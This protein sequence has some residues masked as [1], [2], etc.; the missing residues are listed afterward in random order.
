LAN[1]VEHYLRIAT[2]SIGYLMKVSFHIELMEA[3][4]DTG[5]RRAIPP[6][7]PVSTS[8]RADFGNLFE[9]LR[10]NADYIPA[11]FVLASF[12]AA[13]RNHGDAG[14]L[15]YR[16]V[17]VMMQSMRANPEAKTKAKSGDW[18]RLHNRLQIERSAIDKIK[19][20][21]D[22]PRHG[23]V[24]TITSTDMGTIFWLT[25]E[26]IRR[27]LEYLRRGKKPLS[28]SEFRLLTYPPIR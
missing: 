8:L 1:S 7:R 5:E 19:A 16:A 28:S 17:E 14:L 11:R 27:Y 23:I 18:A 2:D 24:A 10:T 22:L 6:V 12:R 4:S 20:H 21:A 9:A 26:I 13:I 15:C 3:L 25:D